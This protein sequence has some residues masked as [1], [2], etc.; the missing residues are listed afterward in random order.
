MISFVV[1]GLSSIATSVILVGSTAIP[2]IRK[3]QIFP[4]WHTSIYLEILTKFGVNLPNALTYSL[5]V[6]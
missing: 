6:Y 1:F 4:S 5:I 3:I 2:P